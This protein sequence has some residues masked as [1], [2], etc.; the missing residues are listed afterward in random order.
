MPHCFRQT[1]PAGFNIDISCDAMHVRHV[2]ARTRAARSTRMYAHTY[3][4]R[5][6]RYSMKSAEG[7]TDTQEGRI[8]KAGR[9]R[10]RRCDRAKAGADFE[11]TE[12]SSTCLSTG[13]IS[14]IITDGTWNARAHP[15]VA[16][17]P[18][19]L[20]CFLYFLLLSSRPSAPRG[21]AQGIRVVCIVERASEE[22]LD[23]RRGKS[24]E[25]NITQSPP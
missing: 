23:E 15:T 18:F 2:T 19:S 24:S 21:V 1:L 17:F 11:R 6:T 5:D 16:Y 25:T 9:R 14:P 10:R 20:S 8:T 4:P 13:G 3:P 22:R 7:Y 12:K